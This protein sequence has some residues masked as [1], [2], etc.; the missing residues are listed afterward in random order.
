MARD[1]KDNRIAN[2]GGAVSLRHVVAYVRLCLRIVGPD[3]KLVAAAIA[4]AVLSGLFQIA[5]MLLIA[6]V[7]LALSGQSGSPPQISSLVAFGTIEELLLAAVTSLAGV[8][9]VTLPPAHVQALM[10]S[11]VVAR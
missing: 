4:L 7:V 8:V 11:R 1:G 10:A 6:G 2:A 9:L 3:R 5:L